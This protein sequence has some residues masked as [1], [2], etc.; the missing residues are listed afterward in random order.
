[1][2]VSLH[3]FLIVFALA[4]FLVAA[5]A[6]IFQWNLGK[7]NAIAWGLFAWLLAITFATG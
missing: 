4:C 5:L 1:M 7:F 2:T 6:P 3:L